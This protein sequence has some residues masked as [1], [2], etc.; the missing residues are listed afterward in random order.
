MMNKVKEVGQIQI[1]DRFVSL[2]QILLRLGNG[3]V[4]TAFW[5]ETMA[6]VVE[7]RLKDRFDYLAN[8][9]LDQSIHD[10][11]NTKPPL[12]TTGLWQPYPANIAGSVRP[13][14]QITMQAC[15]NRRG[16][17]F[18]H[19]DRLAVQSWCSLVT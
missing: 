4:S 13:I 16:F 3:S 11:G 7:D 19:I 8:R 18:R 10:V 12:P 9:L 1:N 14:Q 15:D 2:R 17:C 6:A 5:P